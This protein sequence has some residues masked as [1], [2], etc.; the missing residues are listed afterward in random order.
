[1]FLAGCWSKGWRRGWGSDC[2]STVIAEEK[3]C[4]VHCSPRELS[5]KKHQLRLWLCLWLAHSSSSNRQRDGWG[6]QTL[7]SASLSLHLSL[8]LS[9][10]LSLLPSLFVTDSSVNLLSS[11]VLSLPHAL[12]PPFFLFPGSVSLLKTA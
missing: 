11:R 1:M 12:F 10:S 5:E 3:S 4:S 2:H 6:Q 7:R 9:P 8:F